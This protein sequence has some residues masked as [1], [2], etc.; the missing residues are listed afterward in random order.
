MTIAVLTVLRETMGTELPSKLDFL[1][2]HE[3]G[4]AAVAFFF[5]LRLELVRLE[6][7]DESGGVTLTRDAAQKRTD[8][9]R[10]LIALAGEMAERHLDPSCVGQG[11]GP[12]GDVAWAMKPVVAR[13]NS[14]LGDRPQ[15]YVDRIRKRM[16]DRLADRCVRL[17]RARWPAIRRLA[18]ELA[19]R[20]SRTPW[21]ELTGEEAERLLAGEDQ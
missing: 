5:G 21:V 18:A 12:D 2:H 8:A 20:A 16:E 3:A 7:D 9:Q 1:T 10:V 17:V 19:S 13:L 14:R 11:K 4:H 15:H 6:P